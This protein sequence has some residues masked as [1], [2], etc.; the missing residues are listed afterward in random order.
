MNTKSIIIL[1]LLFAFSLLTFITCSNIEDKP[2]KKNEVLLNW[3][4]PEDE[5]IEYETVME[6]M[7]KSTFELELGDM[8]DKLKDSSSDNTK[9]EF[10]NK[11]KDIQS[12]TSF[13]T[14]LS[15]SENFQDV[16]DI[17][18]SASSKKHDSNDDTES[19][20]FKNLLKGIVLRGSV[21]KNG[22]MHSFWV[23]NDQKNLLSMFFELPKN[24]VSRGE[25]WT[26]ANVN[27]IGNDQNF[28]CEEAIKK[29]EVTLTDII[30]RNGETIAI[31]NYDIREYVSGDFIQPSFSGKPGS[32][33]KTTMEF[34]Y[35][36]QG[37]FSEDKG[38]WLSLTG[39]LSLVASGVM[40]S[41]QKQKISLMEVKN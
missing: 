31:I 17:E 20:K 8:F 25:T 1:A 13:K 24:P 16:V 14:V 30:D 29:N 40:N 21:N 19:E 15:N 6:E 35:T 39:V 7:E 23:K 3:K 38:K 10:F 2:S 41:N 28:I 22:T 36:A 11:L 5:T 33:T 26:L 34:Q 4:I 12:N 18:M 32:S 27:L 9:E 37:E